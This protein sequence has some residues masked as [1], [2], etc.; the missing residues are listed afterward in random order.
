MEIVDR[1]HGTGAGAAARDEFVRR[2]S[3]G[4]LPE[5]VPE[6]SLAIAG[7]EAK[8]VQVLKEAQ[9]APS[10]SAGYR[11]I[12]QGGV[13]VEGTKIADRELKLAVPGCY[14]IQVGKRAVARVTLHA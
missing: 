10:T 5:E 13:R 6:V 8:L 11:L 7:P 3:Q 14:L 9:L 4:A 12:E 2:F 1:F